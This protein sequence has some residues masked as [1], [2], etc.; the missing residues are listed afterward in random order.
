MYNLKFASTYDFAVMRENNIKAVTEDYYAITRN[1]FCVADGV[2][3]D[4]IDGTSLK[5]PSTKEEAQAVI[6]KYPNPSGAAL[7]STICA[8]SFIKYASSIAKV[9][10]DSV[11]EVMKKINNDIGEINKSR[12]NIDYV[13]ED[14]YGCVAVG[15]IITDDYLYCFSIGDCRIK[16]LDDNFNTTFDTK[17]LNHNLLPYEEPKEFIDLYKDEWK[18]ENP[19]YR[20][21]YRK[22]IRNNVQRFENGEYSFGVLTGEETALPFVKISKVPLTNVK[23]ILAYSDG[24]EECLDSK[25]KIISIIA[26]PEQIKNE[27]HEKTLLIFEK[28]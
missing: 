2:T 11:L 18:W 15:G 14:L 28:D 22:N 5:Y 25:E 16:L 13:R 10:E 19:K 21:Y 6:E 1:L 20:E 7:A 26:N 17:N 8:T 23:Y 24:C 27:A 3:R 12:T 9:S 4:L